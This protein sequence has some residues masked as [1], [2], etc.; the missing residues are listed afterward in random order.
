MRVISATP[1]SIKEAGIVTLETLCDI[2][3]E[4]LPA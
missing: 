3:L 2:L 1:K 4:E